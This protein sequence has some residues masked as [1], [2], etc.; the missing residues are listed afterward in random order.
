MN[1]INHLLG[2]DV[3]SII[4][5]HKLLDQNKLACVSKSIKD[6]VAKRASSFV[7][8][9]REAT[10]NEWFLLQE[11]L[12]NIPKYDAITIFYEDCEWYI[13]GVEWPPSQTQ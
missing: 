8:L 1:S 4:F 3:F 11:L 2:E 6:I 7:S 13:E 10:T 9:K 12:M 5:N